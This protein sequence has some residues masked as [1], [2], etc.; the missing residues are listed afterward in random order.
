MGFLSKGDTLNWEEAQK[1]LQY[2]KTHG[3]KQFIHIYNKHKHRENDTMFWG[4]EV[5]YITLRID[6]NQ[7]TTTLNLRV[8]DVLDVLTKEEEALPADKRVVSWKPE[9]GRFMVE[10][11]PGIPYPPDISSVFS[12]E[13]NMKL[14]RRMLE[15]KLLADEA[16]L[17]LT[18]F[19]LLGVG[20]PKTL[21]PF[22][23]SQFVS[24]E[25]INPHKRFGTLTQNIR[26][27]KGQNVAINV[28]LFFDKNTQSL[29]YEQLF[30]D[31][32]ASG[33]ELP[34]LKDH[35]Y[36]D[37]MVFGMGQ[38]CLQTTFTLPNIK[39]SREVYDKLL[40]L[41]PILLAL[42]AA[43]PILRGYLVDTDVRWNI[44][45]ASV[46]DRTAEELGKVP[47]NKDRYVIDKSR[48]A[49][50]SSYLCNETL[51]VD[52]FSFDEKVF[53]DVPLVQDKEVYALLREQG[54]DH[55][56]AEHIAH[57]F[58]RDPLVIYNDKIEIDDEQF[59]D[60]FEN[61]QSTNWQTL[62][63]KPPPPNSPIG[64]R[65]EF[66]P[67]EANFTDFENAAF[68]TF[69]YLLTR[70]LDSFQLNLYLPLSKVD[71][72][73]AT[74]HKRGAVNNNSFW[75]RK[76]LSPD[77]PNEFEKFSMDALMNGS[78]S[79][80]GL[81]PLVRKYLAGFKF[82][83]QQTQTLERYFSL[84]SAR[85]SGK[86]Q[87]TASWIRDFVASHPNY[88]QDSIV[89]PEITYDLCRAVMDIQ[90]GNLKAPS[91]LGNLYI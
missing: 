25:L 80:V 47:L 71:E 10:A 9:Y 48:Y 41:T 5:E 78:P 39:R 31:H 7:K 13:D 69:I 30:P 56:L 46:D 42:S 2:V 84:L 36:A 83:D 75:F 70:T 73:M 79:F 23:M 21:E 6:H 87:T 26:V 57:L 20:S 91:L 77:S 38:C 53:N 81:I 64:W 14:R 51:Q 44:I 52:G 90:K 45:S 1:F 72:N 62:R 63:W 22:A 4:D 50:V 12:V 29:S 28:P 8:S 61:I 54:I 24:D 34:A 18:H 86:L 35:V 82:T 43:T 33:L 74:A 65:V 27:R 19:P 15:E 67:T 16:I 88:K 55:L 68:A 66:R 11:T 37:A 40:P 17:T 32:V 89:S 76:N 60:H 3:I 85:A 49:S 58:I 59:T